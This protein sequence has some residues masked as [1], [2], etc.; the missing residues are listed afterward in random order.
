MDLLH[1]SCPK[2]LRKRKHEKSYGG[3]GIKLDTT[4]TKKWIMQV[5]KLEHDV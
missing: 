5:V 1:H 2:H 4:H 3:L